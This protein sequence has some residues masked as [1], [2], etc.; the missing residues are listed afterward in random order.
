M[1]WETIVTTILT[2]TFTAGIIT[3]VLKSIIGNWFTKSLEGYKNDLVITVES[4][5][6][7]FQKKLQDFSLF[8]TK[9]H[10][11][12]PHLYSLILQAE[13]QISSLTGLRTIPDFKEYGSDDLRNFLES[14]SIL[15]TKIEEL[16]KLLNIDKELADREINKYLNIIEPQIAKQ[17]F[18]EAKNYY[19][20]HELYLTNSCS[21]LVDKALK[22]IGGLITDTEYYYL[23]KERPNIS[24]IQ[25]KANISSLI[26]DVKEKMRE[27]L[28][29][30]DII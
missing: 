28:S 25:Q 15:K 14:K 19:L 13:G 20:L 27:E 10:E 22:T 17:R 18:N 30:S 29:R 16:V 7:Y 4:Q 8:N 21:E 23:Y 3:F 11:I 24:F 26:L 1:T 5:K 6:N 12:Y 9:K 2:S